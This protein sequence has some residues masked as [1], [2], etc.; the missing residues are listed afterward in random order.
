MAPTVSRIERARKRSAGAKR[1]VAAI[2]AAS[3]VVAGVLA[4]ATHSGHAATRAARAPA[5]SGSVNSATSTSSGNQSS[6]NF[7][8]APSTNS[9][10]NVQTSVS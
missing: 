3:F 10:P 7:S 1:V 5:G 6:D 9:T 4:R 8:I 2:A